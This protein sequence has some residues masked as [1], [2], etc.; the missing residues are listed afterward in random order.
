MSGKDRKITKKQ[1]VFV[2]G[3]ALLLVIGG[4]YAAFHFDVLFGGT[5]EHKLSSCKL[6]LNLKDD[7]PITLVDAVPI[8]DEKAKEYD[9]YKFTVTNKGNC[10]KAYY[11]ISL[12]DV[13]KSCTQTN[14]VCN[15][16]GQSLN[17]TNDYKLNSS[18]IKYELVNK[19]TNEVTKNVNPTKLELIGE[20]AKEEAIHFELRLWIDS[21]ATKEDLYVYENGKPKENSDGSIVTKNAGYKLNVEGQD[22]PTFKPAIEPI[23]RETSGESD[24]YGIWGER[25][26]ITKIVFQNELNP[27]PNS[28]QSWDLSAT[29]DGSVMGY[30]VADSDNQNKYIAYIQGNGKVIANQNSD[31]LFAEFTSLKVIEGLE[32]FDTSNAT[33]MHSMF[34]NASALTTLDLSHFNTS[35]VKEMSNMFAGMTSLTTLDLSHFDTSKVTAMSNMFFR[36]SSL[37][38][39]NLSSF[40][41]SNVSTMKAMFYRTS[42]LRTLDLSNFDTSRVTDMSLMFRETSSL[43]TLN[44]SN[45]NTSNVLT[46]SQMFYESG[47]ENVNLSSFETPKVTDMSWMFTYAASLENLDFRKATFDQVSSV[48]YMF[49]RCPNTIKIVTK[50]AT[51]K[52]WLQERLS[53]SYIT[54]STVTTVE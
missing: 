17:C 12:G 38:N 19:K 43:K 14:G 21:S 35:N 48:D 51:T 22:S 24:S 49:D 31:F 26:N 10:D 32:Y 3:V 46:M 4:T 34:Y 18:K 39:V 5:E 44:L 9:S 16:N 37:E 54:G 27:I 33:T 2:I 13:C 41:T 11:K 47:I 28:L 20:I 7:L 15:V 6:S 50:N 29:E 53:V 30:L 45:F 1:L 36:D 23:M 40:D 25:S 8:S 42:A 52:T